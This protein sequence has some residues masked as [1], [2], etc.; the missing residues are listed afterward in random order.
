M[1]QGSLIGFDGL[2]T[3]SYGEL[4]GIRNGS[5]PHGLFHIA[6]QGFGDRARVTP[7]L[8]GHRDFGD[9]VTVRVSDGRL[10]ILANAQWDL[11]PEDG[12]QPSE[13]RRDP[14]ILFQPVP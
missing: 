1:T 9:P 6:L 12:S 4:Y 11:F 13:P 8:T 5:Q 10:F 14:V 2:A 3:D 7:V